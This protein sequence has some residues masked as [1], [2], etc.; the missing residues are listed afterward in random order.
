MD[1]SRLPRIVTRAALLFGAGAFI[2]TLSGGTP[3]STRTIEPVSL[4]TKL[5]RTLH[6]AKFTGRI[7]STLEARLGRPIDPE[8]AEL[9][10]LLFFDRILG[11]HGDNACAGCHSPSNGFGDTQSMAIGIQS[12]E[13]VGPHRTG[14]R[15]QRRTPM[16]I[17]NA[18]FPKLMWNGRFL[19]P[20]GDP[21]D[22]SQGFTF[23]LPEGTEKFLPADSRIPHLL[24]AQAHIPPTEQIEVA[25]F[26]GAG[27]PFDDG[28]GHPVPEPDASG[29]RNEPIRQ[30]VLGFLNA[31]PA[32][33]AEFGALYPEVAQGGLIDFAMLGQAIAEFEFTLTFADAPI[34]R[35][36]RGEHA[37]MTDA[38]KR[39]ALLFFGRA[40][41]VRCHAVAGGA[42]EMF[43][44]F[45]NHVAGVP[46]IAPVFG[47]G[48]GN[49]LFPGADNDEDF[50][51]E[52]ITADPADRYKFRT[53]PL[54]N[55]ALQPAFFHN[56]AYTRLEDALRHHLDPEATARVYDPFAAGIAF[57]LA[58][59]D[60][61]IDEVL[62]R[63]DP[64][65]Q[66]PVHLSEEEF[67]DL[68]A[69]LRE[70]LLDPRAEPANLE[71]MIPDEVPSGLPPLFF[72][73]REP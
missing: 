70:G 15:N 1:L 72:E 2:A 68:L 55:L 41:C 32:Y 65:L 52:D 3:G 62:A 58:V 40:G 34:D 42:N 64:L 39:G 37:A 25:G 18:F 29:F 20:S 21:F 51:L 47:P 14:P 9:G 49:F 4:D 60:C 33:R 23:P 35:F 57:D 50:G 73:R 10:R 71:S 48:T 66:V 22:N 6:R 36:A 17:N 7:E 69:F 53:S 31:S 5:G 12:N 27:G 59:R 13:V 16:V 63:L 46:Q 28:L 44:D 67:S 24:V 8:L 43:S 38:Q 19:S 56:G 26:T 54:R 11:L 30:T 61:P 45:E